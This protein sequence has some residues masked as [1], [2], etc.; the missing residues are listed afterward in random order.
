MWTEL[1]QG[2]MGLVYRPTGSPYSAYDASKHSVTPVGSA[3]IV[4]QGTNRAAFDFTIEGVTGRKIITRNLFGP[5]VSGAPLKGLGDLWWGGVEQN[6]WGI[7]V[8]QQH[9]NLFSLWFTYDAAGEPIWFAMPAGS[10][11]TPDTYEGRLY[12]TTSSPWLGRTY[13]PAALRVIDVGSFRFS[14][15]GDGAMY[16]YVIDGVPGR[17]PLVRLGF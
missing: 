14:F 6:G 15:S 17:L 1:T 10:W 13:D 4:F 2:Y 5:A 16:D 12:R 3:S 11:T 8:L 9:K 7:T